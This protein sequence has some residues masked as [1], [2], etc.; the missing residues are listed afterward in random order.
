MYRCPTPVLLLVFN[1]PKHAH[2]ILERVRQMQPPRLYIHADGPRAD[3]SGEKELVMATR[4]I[5]EQIDWP[6]AVKTLFRE[7]NAGLRMGVAQA[8]NW[9]FDHEPMGIVLE[10]DCLPDPS[11]FRYCTE[12]LEKY[13]DDERIMHIAGSNLAQ[14]FTRQQ[15][16]SYFFSRHSLVW[17]WASWRRAWQHML[18][19]LADLDNFLGSP[20]FAEAVPGRMERAYLAAKFKATQKRENNSWAYAWFYSVLKNNGL[21]VIPSQ[22]LVQNIGVGEASATHTSEKNTAAQ[23]RASALPF[24][25]QHPESFEINPA[26]EQ[27]IFYHTQKKSNRLP[28]WF[29]LHQLGLR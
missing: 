12:L 5:L 16:D 17:G 9:F 29:L 22:N 1:R 14:R 27:Q 28:L 24:P 25:L 20:V 26:L 18:P 8:I 3:R 7:T 13:A 10:D 4:S 15:A 19:E 21:C 11:F 23:I 2:A 6:C